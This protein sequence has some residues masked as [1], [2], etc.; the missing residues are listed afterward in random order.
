MLNGDF[1]KFLI[2]GVFIAADFAKIPFY[3]MQKSWATLLL[4]FSLPIELVHA[5]TA[6]APFPHWSHRNH[7]GSEFLPH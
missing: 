6:P 4:V 2:V 1:L 5:T 7:G 3:K